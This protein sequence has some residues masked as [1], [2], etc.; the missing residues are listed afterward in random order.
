MARAD[1]RLDLA[2]VGFGH[3]GRRF[4]RLLYERRARL[5]RDVGL[6]WRIVGVAT[7]RHGLA[8]DLKGL[9]VDR[10]LD[11]DRDASVAPW[12]APASGPAP[13]DAIDLITRLSARVPAGRLVVVETTV[14]NVTDGQPAIDH[15]RTALGA[16]A[17]VITAN[18]GPVAFGCRALREL[19]DRMGVCWLFEGA[20]LDG[21]PVFNLVR[22]TLP[23][24]RVIGFR[25]V[26]NTTTNYILA[27]MEAGRELGDA[28]AEMQAAGIAEADPGLDVD[29]WD[30]ATKTAALVNALMDGDVTPQQVDRTG[31]GH[32][33]TAEVRAAV[34]RGRR[35]KLVA[36]AARQDAGIVARVAP[37]ELPATDLLATL[38]GP[39]NAL[40]L[41]TDL[42]GEIAIGEMD[43]GLTH[44]AYALLSDLVTIGRRLA[45]A[46]AA[47]LRRTP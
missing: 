46:P 15:V 2:L 20:V 27:A 6:A 29:G 44:T 37:M 10:L 18:K 21:I 24:V 19:A 7:R 36:S 42:L 28:L 16:G 41:R 39:A 35:V 40:V 32:L 38:A 12:R 23:T 8:I 3:V 34:D 45:G 47:A 17:H 25:G 26:V 33:T 5:E 30:A 4:A 11:A 14:L 13:S 31:I 43:S 9:D 22:E 1:V